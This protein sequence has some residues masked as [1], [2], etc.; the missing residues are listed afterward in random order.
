MMKDKSMIKF[1]A[2]DL[3]KKHLGDLDEINKKNKS[4]EGSVQIRGR[5]IM[6]EHMSSNPMILEKYV[7][8]QK[9]RMRK[10]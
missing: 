6:G 8:E 4:Q 7:Y 2:K 9:Q 10:P 3:M 5:E 1:M